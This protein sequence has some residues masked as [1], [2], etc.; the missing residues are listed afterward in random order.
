MQRLGFDTETRGDYEQ[1]KS[2]ATGANWVHQQN[3]GIIFFEGGTRSRVR[4][5][6]IVLAKARGPDA[7]FGASRANFRGGDFFIGEITSE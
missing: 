6:D 5:R 2:R 7:R 3:P 1:W 4:R